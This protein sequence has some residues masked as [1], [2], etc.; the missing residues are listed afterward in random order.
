MQ[1]ALLHNQTVLFYNLL[2]MKIAFF[3]LDFINFRLQLQLHT[4]LYIYIYILNV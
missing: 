2:A 4:S 3:I 1:D